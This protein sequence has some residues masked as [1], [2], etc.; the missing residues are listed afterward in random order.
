MTKSRSLA[1]GRRSTKGKRSAKGKRSTKGK[2][3]IKRKRS[4]KGKRSVRKKRTGGD[5][6]FTADEK[7]AIINEF[8]SQL[9]DLQYALTNNDDALDSIIHFYT[10]II[11]NANPLLKVK[12]FREVLFNKMAQINAKENMWFDPKYRNE[13]NSNLNLLK[14]QYFQ[15]KTELSDILE[16][17]NRLYD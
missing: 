3:S 10:Y 14:P 9:P 1:K 12:G 7:T 17:Y 6:L 8:K 11:E 5:A 4:T 2:R 16:K 15:K 13:N